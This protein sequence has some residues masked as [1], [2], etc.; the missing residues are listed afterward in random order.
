MILLLNFFLFSLLH[1]SNGMIQWNIYLGTSDIRQIIEIGPSAVLSSFV[2]KTIDLKFVD[3][4]KAKNITR[5]VK[6]IV[7]EH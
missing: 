1:L 6:S 2:Q 3:H 5:S 7:F 4:D